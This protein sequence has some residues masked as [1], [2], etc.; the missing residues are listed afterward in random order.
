MKDYSRCIRNIQDFP[1]KG[2]LFRDITPLLRDAEA[3][4][5]V[6]QQFAKRYKEREIDVIAAVESRGFLF[7]APLACYMGL[8][9]VPIRKKGKLPWKVASITYDLEYGQDVLEIHQD[10]IK[11]GEKVLLVDD[12]IATGGSLLA[13]AQ[14]IERLGGEVVEIATVIELADLKGREKLI[15]YPLF[16]LIKY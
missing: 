4:N 7:A 15:D 14:L 9:L 12:L 5:E 10:A 8:G 11:P 6:I 3:F 16:S 13:S 1:V 2:V